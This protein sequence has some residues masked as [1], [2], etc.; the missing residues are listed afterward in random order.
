MERIKTISNHLLLSNDNERN[1]FIR[2]N[3]TNNQTN[4]ISQKK[5]ENN[6]LITIIYTN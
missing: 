1:K 3:E 5:G 4:E 6:H 2:L